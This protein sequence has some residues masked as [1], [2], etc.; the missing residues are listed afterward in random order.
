MKIT[1]VILTQISGEWDGP[2][3]P[4][5]NRQSQA[6]DVYPEL[7]RGKPQAQRDNSPRVVR[8]IYLEIQSDEGISGIFGPIDD[9]Q[10]YV[11]DHFLRPFLLGRDP[12]ATEALID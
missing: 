8:D 3:F 7:S 12:L 1:D 9:A 10:A 2:E 5:G 4:P 6:M 11:I